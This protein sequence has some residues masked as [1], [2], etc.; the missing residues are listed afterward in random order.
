[1]DNI[2]KHNSGTD[3]IVVRN[4]VKMVGELKM[5]AIA[6]GVETEEQARFLKNIDCRLVQGYL[7]DKPLPVED[8]VERLQNR[9]Y[10]NDV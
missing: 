10:E 8:F 6:E 5:K 9:K 7:F 1:M 2:E 3:E 4:I